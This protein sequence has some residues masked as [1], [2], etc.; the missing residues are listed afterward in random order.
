MKTIYFR[1]NNNWGSGQ[2]RGNQIA[3]MISTSGYEADTVY[4]V[5]GIKNSIIVFV[6]YAPLQEVEIAKANGNIIIYDFVDFLANAPEYKISNL[7]EFSALCSMFDVIIHTTQSSLDY[8]KDKVSCS[9]IVIPHH[10]D[11]RIIYP[12]NINKNLSL[13]YVG[14]IHNLLYGDDIPELNKLILQYDFSN[15]LNNTAM[16]NCHYTVRTNTIESLYKPATKVFTAAACN[17]N[18]IASKDLN[19]MEFLPSDYPYLTDY[20]LESV[21]ATVAKVVDTFGSDIWKYG[22]SI[23][24][25]IRF[26]TNIYTISKSY[27]DLFINL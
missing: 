5:D 23:M 8:M 19:V 12:I 15:F 24:E 27:I 10:Y 1:K 13:G 22:M 18:I 14:M 11:P 6:K 4:S 21:K 20:D 16:F 2:M 26:K 3:G 25:E 7:P 9:M 17:A